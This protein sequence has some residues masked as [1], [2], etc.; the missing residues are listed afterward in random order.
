VFES[1]DPFEPV[2]PG[3]EA[4]PLSRTHQWSCDDHR[5]E[6]GLISQPLAT[7]EEQTNELVAVSPASHGQHDQPAGA[8]RE[9]SA[10][11]S[12]SSVDRSEEH[13]SELQSRFDLVCRLLLE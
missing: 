5:L 13:T 2:G 7:F 9:L 10:D 11:I 3:L 12:R 4:L 6:R 8:R 1:G